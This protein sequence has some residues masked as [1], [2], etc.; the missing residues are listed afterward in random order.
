MSRE[1]LPKRRRIACGAA[2]CLLLLLAALALP[3]RAGSEGTT[4][5]EACLYQRDL[6]R[7]ARVLGAGQRPF[8]GR[9]VAEAEGVPTAVAPLAGDD[10][11]LAEV[12]DL[13][14]RAGAQPDSVL[15][16]E[17]PR[18]VCS[19]VSLPQAELDAERRVIVAAGLNY[20]THAEEVGG[21][22]VFVFPKPAAPTPPYGDVP[23]PEHV[24]LLDYEVELA[25]V[26]LSDLRLG[27]LPPEA[28]LLE[29]LAFFVANDVT[30]REPILRNA[31]LSGPGTGYVEAKG[32]PGFLPTGPWMVRGSELFAALAA[33]GAQGLGLELAVDEGRGFAPRQAASTERMILDVR[34]FLAR[35]GEEVRRSGLRSPMPFERSGETR[36]YPLAQ[37]A[38]APRLPAGSLVLT[39]TP[40]GVALRV[41][42]R[43][44]LTLRALLRLRS[45][46]E[47]LVR[48]ERA[49][50]AA[51]GPGGYLEPG[52][53]VRARIDGLGAQLV[54]IAAPGETLARNPCTQTT[55]ADAWRR[56]LDESTPADRLRGQHA[57]MP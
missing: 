21:G 41:P 30:N 5:L 20:A 33:C 38:E 50:A 18:R 13:A 4:P 43:A 40:D 55:S 10:R 35:I 29:R 26:L 12:F 34:A 27:E 2:A 6:P 16:I 39:G 24:A 45:P 32:Q 11:A 19:P 36:Y 48:E 42:N 7:V 23:L 17:D 22:D 14:A 28:E 54:R 51:G 57:N 8:Y 44:A 9:V 1:H 3:T 15:E 56:G 25:F 37:D 49:R 46:F 52:D 31:A 53:R 47:Q